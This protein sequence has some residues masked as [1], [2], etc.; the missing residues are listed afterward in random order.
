M[1]SHVKEL[2]INPSKIQEKANSFE[3]K[4]TEEYFGILSLSK[5]WC[6]IL[7][8]SH[9]ANSHQGFCVGFWEEKLRN[10]ISVLEGGQ[11]CYPP[12]NSFPRPDPIGN[13]KEN[14]I[15]KYLT[16]SN[17]WGYEEEYRMVK[18]FFEE[19]PP[20][21][22]TIENRIT[23]FPDD[24]IAEIIIGLEAS[25]QAKSEILQMAKDKR[26][27][28]YQCIKKPFKFELDRVQIL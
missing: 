14:M 3:F 5:R 19:N 25:E 6:S 21:I 22:P 28:V 17:E 23:A 16:K 4:A 24:C 7:M 10:N 9:Y 20:K 12:D 27:P 2:R 18:L 11:V 13:P 1:E 8:W 15:H 26:K